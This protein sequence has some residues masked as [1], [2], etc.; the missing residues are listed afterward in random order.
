MLSLTVD[1]FLVH[2]NTVT[3][4]KFVLYLILSSIVENLNEKSRLL[5]VCR[6]FYAFLKI[7][8]PLKFKDYNQTSYFLTDSNQSNE[9]NLFNAAQRIVR[10]NKSQ[11]TGH[12]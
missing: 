10:I 9:L 5:H 8:F 4:I 7:Y 1:G 3:M 11:V 12:M 2:T 6:F